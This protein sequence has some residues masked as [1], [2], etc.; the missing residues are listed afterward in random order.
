LVKKENAILT[1]KSVGDLSRV[2]GEKRDS[3]EEQTVLEKRTR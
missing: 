1:R 3:K 2:K